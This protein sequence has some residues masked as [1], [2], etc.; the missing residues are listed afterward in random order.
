MGEATNSHTLGENSITTQ[1]SD[2]SGNISRSSDAIVVVYNLPP[3]APTGLIATVQGFD[4]SLSWNPNLETDLAGYNLYRDGILL[5][6][7][8]PAN[9]GTTTAS[10]T[11]SGF[12]PANAIDSDPS[13]YWA[14]PTSFGTFT[15]VWWEVQLTSPQLIRQIEIQW[16]SQIVGGEEGSQEFLYAGKDF[17]ILVWSGVAWIPQ[18][19]VIGNNEQVNAYD[20]IPS[21][22]TDRIRISITETT[23]INYAKQLWISEVRLYQHDLISTE[24]YVD[25]GLSDGMYPYVVTAVDTYGFESLPSNSVDALVGD[26]TP[27]QHSLS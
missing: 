9:L 2:A 24:Q 11:A 13:T 27:H 12:S 8:I 6:D 17:E 10:L 19:Q 15:P 18:V 14:P 1:V 5:N 22:S 4:V 16:G 25:L 20:F 26:L 23:D 3:V 7:P 21:Y